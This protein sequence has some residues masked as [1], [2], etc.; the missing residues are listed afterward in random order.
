MKIRAEVQRKRIGVVLCF[1][2]ASV[3]LS[4]SLDAVLRRLRCS[5]PHEST[6]YCTEAQRKHDKRTTIFLSNKTKN[7]MKKQLLT[8]ILCLSIAISGFAQQSGYVTRTMAWE[9]DAEGTLT[10]R[11]TGAMPD[12]DSPWWEFHESIQRVVISEGITSIRTRAF[13]FH[14]KLTSI[15]VSP[16]NNNYT[17]ENG[18]LFDKAMTTLVVY[19]AGKQGEYV[20]P[21]GITRIEDEAFYH[22][23]GLTSITI[24]NSVTSIGNK[25]FYDCNGLTSITIPNSITRI[26]DDV[27][28]GCSKLTSIAIPNSITSIG[29]GAFHGCKLTS[30]TIPESVTSIGDKAFYGCHSLETINIPKSVTNIGDWAFIF[31]SSLTLIDVSPEN[32]NYT[33][34]DGVLFD[35]TMTTLIRCLSSKKG[36]Y[37]IPK[38]VKSIGNSAFYYCLGLKSIVIPSSVTN[39]DDK[40]FAAC[41]NLD[42]ITIPNSVTNIGYEA[43]GGCHNL[44]SIIIPGSIAHIKD[45]AFEN[46]YGLTSITISDGITSIGDRAFYSCRNLTSIT[47]PDGVTSIGSQ[48]FSFCNNLTS[49]TIPNSVTSIGGQAFDGCINLTSVTI[50]NS[51]TSIGSWAFS[52]CNALTRIE[53][54][55]LTPSI[56]N[57]NIFDNIFKR[58]DIKAKC[59]L[60][61]PAESVDAYKAA[62]Y[63]KDCN[64]IFAISKKKK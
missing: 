46:C 2:C 56:I 63:W 48:A 28:N 24:P 60:Y 1:C 55:I 35:K 64:N 36:R 45:K 27:F 32:N 52:G 17:S 6:Q 54:H 43:F 8:T 10:I 61:V 11:G 25:A 49:V 21:Y 4:L 39:I 57:E 59:T 20:I 47:I 37:I 7:R 29:N 26:E 15:E 9:L 5:T 40:A 62:E 50:P 16:Q 3:L 14:E 38:S 19:P 30:V 53:S 58:E 51:V 34:E 22:C 12:S 41:M 42:S 23:R 31:C 18:V 13:V 44:T 33:F